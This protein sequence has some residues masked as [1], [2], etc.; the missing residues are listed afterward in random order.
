MKRCGY[1]LTLALVIAG[2]RSL[3]AYDFGAHPR[4]MQTERTEDEKAQVVAAANRHLES[5]AEIPEEYGQW[6]FYYA[7][8]EHNRALEC[9]DGSHVC[10]T[11]SKAYDTEQV[12]RAYATIRHDANNETALTLAQAY[13]LT[14]DARYAAE[15][16]RILQRYARLCPTWPRHD[17]WGRF[18]MLAIIGGKR[19]AQSLDDA[20]GI[21][22]LARAYDLLHDWDG[23]TPEARRV[24]E[25]DLFRDTVESIYAMYRAYDGKNNHQTWYNAAAAIVATVLGDAATLD[26]ALHGA[27]GLSTQMKE[28]V[29]AEGL[30][31]EGAIAYHF[32][33][34]NALLHTLDAAHGAGIALTDEKAVILK[35]LTTPL[36]IA[37]PNGQLPAIH[38]SDFGFLT[39][40]RSLYQ[41][42]LRHFDH[43][44]LAAFA[45]TGEIPR[46]ESEVM[47]D[48]GLVFLRQWGDSPVTV[49]MDFGQHGG[50]HGHPDKLNLLVYADGAELFPDTGRLTYRCPEYETWARQTIAHNTVVINGKSQKPDHGRITHYAYSNNAHT[51]TAESTGAYPGVTLRRTLTLHD[52]GTLHDRFD[53]ESPAPLD[54]IELPL[55]SMLPVTLSA[56]ENGDTRA[57]FGDN[58]LAATFHGETDIILTNGIGYTLEERLPMLIRHRANAASATFSSTYTLR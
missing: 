43:P 48:I 2:S 45:A 28:S 30:W 8:A 37:Y 57:T 21:I 12:R 13:A 11:C 42:A 39:G 49:I 7:C 33:A 35:M 18:G 15:A 16:W 58:G 24:V 32:Y 55:H 23:I 19:Y 31:Y 22:P 14:G 17:R 46:T 44:L 50:H 10:P 9:R 40:Y 1:A 3:S 25:K 51:V 5:P 56:P 52:D 26:K 54:T 53:V 4:L 6:Y 34:L 27:K 29:T 47:D 38:D 41:T 20:C 36:R